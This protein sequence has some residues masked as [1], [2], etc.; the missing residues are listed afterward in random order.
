VPGDPDT[1]RA[2]AI[3]QNNEAWRLLEKPD[4]TPEEEA[5]M[6]EAAKTS[7][8]LWRRVGT[9]VNEQRGVWMIART[10]VDAG[11]AGPALEFA[12]KTLA[13]TRQ[14]HDQLQDF[15]LA[16]A[17]EIMARALALSGEHDRAMIH[18]EAARALGNAIAGDGD[19]K[20]FFAQFQGGPWF[21]FAQN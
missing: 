4:R 16:F 20:A 12:E 2:E 18:W 7:L 5:A 17:Q 11:M 13:L 10:C 1:I 21:G 19:R 14:H 9:P 3:A 6:L 8:D 15:D